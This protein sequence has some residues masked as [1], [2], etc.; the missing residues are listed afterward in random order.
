MLG[1]V[2]EAEDA[3]QAT[4]LVSSARPESVRVDDSL[5]RWLYGVAHR[6]AAPGP[7]RGRAAQSD[8]GPIAAGSSD[9]PAGEVERGELRKVLGE[10][11]DRLPTKYRCPIELCDLQGMT[12]DQASRQLNWSVATV[13][14][15]LAR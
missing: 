6:V 14:G 8:P 15:R 11:V 3:F 10:E 13:K 1:D 5:G 9:D 12:Y 2:H 4:F 7:V